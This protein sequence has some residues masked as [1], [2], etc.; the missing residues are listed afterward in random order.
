MVVR[1]L[2]RSTG[3]IYTSG[4]PRKPAKRAISSPNDLP[5]PIGAVRE[6]IDPIRESIDPVRKPID[7][8]RKPMDA[9]RESID[10]VPKVTD[11]VWKPIHA[12]RESIDPVPKPIHAVRKLNDAVPGTKRPLSAARRGKNGMEAHAKEEQ[13]FAPFASFACCVLS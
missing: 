12:L 6:S 1:A 8:V 10:Q 2:N 11:A 5:N 13:S 9:V 4:H 3:A 7:P